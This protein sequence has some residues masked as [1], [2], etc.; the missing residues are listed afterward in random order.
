M[1]SENDECQP[2]AKRP[3]LSMQNDML[4]QFSYYIY[5]SGNEADTEAASKNH[6]KKVQLAGRISMCCVLFNWTDYL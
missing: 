4:L 3:T 6:G 2:A 5:P 1:A